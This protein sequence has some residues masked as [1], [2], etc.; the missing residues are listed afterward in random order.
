[1]KKIIL[2]KLCLLSGHKWLYKDYSNWMKEN[3][4]SYDFQA[5]RCCSR[6]NQVEYYYTEWRIE[7]QKSP[8]D[9]EWDSQY[10]K[11]LEHLETN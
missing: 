8:Y 9:V 10:V 4:D 6:C 7:S 11:Q 5:S 1:M 3:G 2:N